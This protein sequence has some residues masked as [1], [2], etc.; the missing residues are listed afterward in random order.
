MPGCDASNTCDPGG[1]TVELNHFVEH[2]VGEAF[3]FRHAVA[4]LQQHY[5]VRYYS[6]DDLGFVATDADF[7]EQSHLNP[8][9]ANRFTRV[10][11]DKAVGPNLPK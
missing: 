4:D 3:D 2:D 5:D 9:G 8:A 6:L 7:L 1:T 10:L 11:A